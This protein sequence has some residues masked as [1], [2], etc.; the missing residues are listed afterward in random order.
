MF[1]RWE[2]RRTREKAEEAIDTMVPWG[3]ANIN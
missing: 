2:R 1:G 3:A